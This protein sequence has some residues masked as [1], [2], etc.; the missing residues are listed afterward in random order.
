VWARAAER[1]RALAPFE[2]RVMSTRKYSNQLLLSLS[3]A[4]LALI[5]PGLTAVILDVRKP[6]ER[7]NKSITHV[8]FPD[9][10]VIS[11][12]VNRNESQVEA[13]IVGREGMTGTAVVLC[14]HRSPNEAYVQIAGS[15]HRISAKLFRE[16]LSASKTLILRMQRFAH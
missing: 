3:R 15:G 12:V 2:A 4:D 6:I 9:S 13:G 10:G 5:A 11:V 1:C 8:H 14:N 16:A 7:A